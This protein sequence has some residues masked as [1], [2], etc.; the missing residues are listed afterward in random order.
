MKKL[1][2]L[3]LSCLMISMFLFPVSAEEAGEDKVVFVVEKT[4]TMETMNGTIIETETDVDELIANP[5]M[6]YS[7]TESQ[8]KSGFT[9]Y[10]TFN[11]ENLTSNPNDLSCIFNGNQWVTNSSGVKLGTDKYNFSNVGSYANYIDNE[12]VNSFTLNWE[13]PSGSNKINFKW[14]VYAKHI[15]K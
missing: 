8:T 6:R 10:A 12:D 5:K 1:I 2:N 15:D 4:M 3:L 14:T 9:V 11:Y 13:I 7:A